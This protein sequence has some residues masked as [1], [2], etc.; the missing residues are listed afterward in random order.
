MR[1]PEGEYIR[2]LDSRHED[3]LKGQ[4]FPAEDLVVDFFNTSGFDTRLSTSSEDSGDVDI[5]PRQTIDAVT[6]YEGKPAMG[7][8][9]TTSSLRDVRE[10]K[11]SE[12]RRKPFLRLDEM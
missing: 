5:G 10:K 8:Q 9:I 1:G 4:G 7:L 2:N 12:I 6:Y 11:L 3:S